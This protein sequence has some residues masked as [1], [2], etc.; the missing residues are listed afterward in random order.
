MLSKTRL[1]SSMATTIVL[2]S[3]LAKITSAACLV[4]SVPL[5]PIQIPTSACFIA[6][7]SFTP[8]P[9]IATIAPLDCN[10]LT[11]LNLCSGVVLANID[12][13]GSNF[14]NSSSFNDSTSIPLIPLPFIPNSLAIAIAVLI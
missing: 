10:A 9:V 12:G 1:P 13:N 4:I 8:S 11:I 7:A 6:L 3:S 2:K 14:I 5:I